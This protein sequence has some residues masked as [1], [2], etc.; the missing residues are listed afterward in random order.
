MAATPSPR[1]KPDRSASKVR[2]RPSLASIPRSAMVIQMVG[3]KFKAEPATMAMSASL[4]CRDWLPKWKQTRDDEQAVSIVMLGP[5]R[6]K[7]YEIRLDRMLLPQPIIVYFGY[8]LR[9][10][11]I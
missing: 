9:S 1:A 5:R 6:S 7:K 4:C 10:M 3:S 2:E 8:I 11:P